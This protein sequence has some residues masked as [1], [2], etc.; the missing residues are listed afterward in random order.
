MNTCLNQK[1]KKCALCREIC[2]T[3]RFSERLGFQSPAMAPEKE[4]RNDSVMLFLFLFLLLVW[5]CLGILG[6]RG[7]RRRNRRRWS[8]KRNPRRGKWG[9]TWHRRGC[10][11]E[12]TSMEMENLASLFPLPFLGFKFQATRTASVVLLGCYHQ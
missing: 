8:W 10:A 4:T 6:F 2:E 9:R 1:Q 3:Y 7:K 5:S 11:C 12:A